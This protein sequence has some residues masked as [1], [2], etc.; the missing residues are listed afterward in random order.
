MCNDKVSELCAGVDACH[1]E[2]GDGRRAGDSEM[3]TS[4]CVPARRRVGLSGGRARGRGPG[5]I[6][7]R[8]WVAVEGLCPRSPLVTLGPSMA[9]SMRGHYPVNRPRMEREEG[10]GGRE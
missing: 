6:N 2:P 4:R 8:Y 7:G 10:S 9:L 5:L 1:R 3:Q